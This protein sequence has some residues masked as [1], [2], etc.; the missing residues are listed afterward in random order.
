[1]ASRLLLLDRWIVIYFCLF[2]EKMEV[3]HKSA[4]LMIIYLLGLLVFGRPF[5]TEGDIGT[6]WHWY[7]SLY[8][9][10]GLFVCTS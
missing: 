9:M 1:M 5:C 8:S 2:G 7:F 3:Y 6:S 10:T 4:L